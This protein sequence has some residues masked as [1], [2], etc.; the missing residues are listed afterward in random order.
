MAVISI[1]NLRPTG[2]DLFDSSESYLQ[3]LT[4]IELE[5]TVGGSTPYT[6]IP[7]Y[8]ALT[9]TIATHF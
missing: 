1:S 5:N 2:A 6:L 7:L 4:D 9:I 3:D 8:S